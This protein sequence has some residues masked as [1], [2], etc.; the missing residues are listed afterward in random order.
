MVPGGGV[1][2]LS[3]NGRDQ[4]DGCRYCAVC[5][6]V[7]AKPGEPGENG[8]DAGIKKPPGVNPGAIGVAPR[9]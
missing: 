5:L 1:W 7:D 6:T 9:R 8:L 2:L 4:I 3:E